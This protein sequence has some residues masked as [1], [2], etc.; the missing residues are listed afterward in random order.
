MAE[1]VDLGDKNSVTGAIE[2]IK[3]RSTVK[4]LVKDLRESLP[5]IYSALVDERDEY[6]TQSLLSRLSEQ[7]RS[8]PQRVVAVVGLAHEDGINRRLARAGYAAAP[9]PPRRLCQAV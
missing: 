6:M 4:E 2:T 7:P 9:A 1:P 5:S 8:A 3:T